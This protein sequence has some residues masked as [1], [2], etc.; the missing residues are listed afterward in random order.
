MKQILA[1]AFGVWLTMTTT[2]LAQSRNAVVVELFTSQGCS[3]CP[4]ADALLSALTQD[5]RVIPLA[6]HVDYWDY[7][8]WKDIFAT[9]QFSARQKAYARYAREKMVYTPQMVIDGKARIVGSRVGELGSALREAASD[10]PEVILSLSRNGGNLEIRAD[11]VADMNQPLIVQLVRF[12]KEQDVTIVRG[13][14]AGKTLRYHNIVISWKQVG[15]W[16]G[17]APLMLTTPA[18]GPEPVV[19]IVQGEGPAEI[20]GAA[21]LE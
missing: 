16:S 15:R 9:P 2:G 6:L 1:V 7:L 13:E 14:N 8:G 4:P 12:A 5:P 21:V 3:A 19:V 11:A 17:R 18:D 10:P 20:F